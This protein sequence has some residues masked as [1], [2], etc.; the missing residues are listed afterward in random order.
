MRKTQRRARR[1][2]LTAGLGAVVAG[3]TG[4]GSSAPIVEHRGEVMAVAPGALTGVDVGAAQTAFGLDLLG[5][6][7][8]QR[9]GENLVLSPT[10]AAE[11]LGLLYPAAGGQT[12]ESVGALLHLPAWSPDLVAAMADHTGA[13]A[14]LAKDGPTDGP[15]APD[16][17]Q[18]SNRI[19]T[20]LGVEPEQGYLDDVATA[21][22]AA[23]HSVDFAGDPGGATDRINQSV[24]EDTRGLIKALYDAPLPA[25]T[26]VVLTN[27][28]YLHA[29]WAV[30]FTETIPAPFAA[31]TGQTSV[32]MMTG[33]W[34]LGRAADGWQSV[35]LPYRDGTL[36]ATAIL[37]PVGTDPCAVDATV[38]SSLAASGTTEVSVALPRVTIEQTHELLDLLQG[39]GL[40]ADGDY[41]RLGQAGLSI[42]GVVQ[43]AYLAVDE[44]GTVAAAATGI[45]LAG[46]APVERELVTFDRPY[47]LLLTDTATASP[48]FVAVVADPS[49]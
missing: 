44:D 7:C 27:A 1:L 46:A 33:A 37:P 6:V 31:P 5:A 4:C 38:L 15:D 12:A 39:L 32:D 49:A 42:S 43:K 29:R 21:F 19:W 18:M 45:G 34:G 10:S 17:L 11:A 40:P 23:V 16:S 47:L 35:V 14:A 22:D 2:L 36:T 9:P 13:L 24:R 28:L 8:A 48:L 30:P 3:L 20:A 25:S 41:S 26:L